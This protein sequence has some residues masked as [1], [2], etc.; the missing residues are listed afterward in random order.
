[1]EGAEY[2]LA[3]SRY[4]HLNPVRVSGVKDWPV[5][6]QVRY[7]RSYAWGTYASYIGERKAFDFVEY[8]PILGEMSGGRGA[9]PRRYRE[10]VE[11]GIT[12]R[13]EDLQL[14]LKASPRSIGGAGFRGWVDE[15]YQK[16]V[17]SGSRPEDAAF[18]RIT[19]VL[20]AD[21]VLGI[22]AEEAGVSVEEFNHRRRDSY[23]R[24]IAGRYLVKYAGLTQ[25]EVAAR[26]GAG[27]GGA[28]SRQMRK[29]RG[30]IAIDRKLRQL[31]ERADKRMASLRQAISKTKTGAGKQC[32]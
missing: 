21:M 6:E 4:V 26:I 23:L 31:V 12:E 25:R 7:L 5:A 8:G 1:M 14:A 11:R 29:V 30:L 24:G 18:R 9:W 19:E 22:L 27:S 17:E 10:F 15:L 3:L 2:L 20:P 32:R 16:L 13:D 28:I